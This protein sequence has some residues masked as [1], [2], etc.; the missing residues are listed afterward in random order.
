MS[1]P[2]RITRP[3]AAVFVL[4]LAAPAA[5]AQLAVFDPQN[6]AQSVKQAENG[7]RMVLNQARQIEYQARMIE[8]QI[9]VL[10]RATD[11]E[12]WKR[13]NDS[14]SGQIN[15]IRRIGRTAEGVHRRAGAIYEVF[16]PYIAVGGGEAL[17][18]EGPAVAPEQLAAWNLDLVAASRLA[19][20]SQVTVA[21]VQAANETA[22]VILAESRDADGQV[23]QLQSANAMLGNISMQLGDISLSASA[24]ADLAA[25]ATATSAARAAADLAAAERYF[26]APALDPSAAQGFSPGRDR[27]S[28]NR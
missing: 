6:F 3:A 4:A 22:A 15:K 10:E 12:Y 24:A 17:A 5:F 18:A 20:E 21:E 26:E 8:H 23:R 25:A 27:V 19:R 11:S 7:A 28:G 16:E 9:R 14:L 2:A 13:G 1:A